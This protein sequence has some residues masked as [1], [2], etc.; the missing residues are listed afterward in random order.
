MSA[1]TSRKSPIVSFK[2]SQ[3]KALNAGLRLH[4]LELAQQLPSKKTNQ[5]NGKSFFDNKWITPTDL[6]RS[7]NEHIQELVHFAETDVNAFIRQN[8]PQ[9]TLAIRSM[10]CMVSE[11]GMVGRRH[12]HVGRISGSYYVDAGESGPMGG[13]LEF[14]EDEKSSHPTF[15]IPPKTGML[16]VFPSKLQH[17]VST[18]TGDRPRIVIAM[19]FA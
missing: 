13:Q 18:Y 7:D 2:C 16:Y 11:P 10:W 17:S 4:L 6:Y 19:N 5:P 8:S 12:N 3:A 9:V 1:K 15:S 14:Y